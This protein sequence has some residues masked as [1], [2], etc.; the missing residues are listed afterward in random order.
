MKKSRRIISGVIAC[1]LLM[2]NAPFYM[3]GGL[4]KD[5]AKIV[6]KAADE[7]LPVT[8]DG[9]TYAITEE[10]AVI[11]G[12]TGI[13]TDITIPST[14]ESKNVVTIGEAA[15]RNN[16]IIESV[17]IPA[18][19]TK[20]EERAFVNCKNLAK[21][22]LNEGLETIG[23]TAFY[24]TAIEEIAI[25]STLTNAYSAFGCWNGDNTKLKKIVFPANYETI[26]ES[27]C[28]YCN[29]LEEIVFSEDVTT[30][31]ERAFSGCKLT[32]IEF[33]DTVET[34]GEG[35]FDGCTALKDVTLNKGLKTIGQSAFYN[36][37]IEEISIPAT[38][39]NAY[40]AFGYWNGD[41]TNLKKITFPKNYET[42]PEAICRYCNNLE[43]IVFSENI[44]TI[45]ERAFSGCKLTAIEFPD[46]VETIGESAFDGCT[47]L[48]DVTLNK[49]LKTIG[50]SAFYN[51]AIEEISIPASLTEAYSA[52]GYW[53]GDNTNLKKVIF[54]KN[55]ETIP[56]SICRYC[57]NLEE[58]VFSV[59]V[60]TIGD[61]AFEGCSSLTSLEVPDTVETIGEAAFNNCTAMSELTLNEGLKTIGQSAF[62]NT[63]IEEVKIPSTLTSGFSAFGYWNGS[64]TKLKKAVIAKRATVIPDSLFRYCYAL[65][66]VEIPETVETIGDNAFENCT[67]LA[68]IKLNEGLTTIG[69]NAFY[70]TAIT[71]ITIP[72]TVTNAAS[73]FGYWN[74]NATKLENVKFADGAKTIPEIMFDYCHSL[75]T[76]EIPDTIEEIG[77]Y[78]FRNCEV[79]TTING[80]QNII[81]FHN[82]S[83]ENCN[84]FFDNR[85]KL[86]TPES[87][88]Q[89]NTDVSYANGI[90]NYTIRYQ[91]KDHVAAD[92]KNYSL[93]LDIPDGMS[94]IPES[95]SSDAFDA[96]TVDLTKKN[97]KLDKNK[98]VV[99]F[100]CRVDKNSNYTV[101]AAIN[102]N[103]NNEGWTQYIDKLD[104]SAAK[105]TCNAPETTNTG[106]IAVYGITEKGADVEIYVDDEKITTVKAN[107]YTGKY[108][109]DIT[110][111]EKKKDTYAI[112]AQNGK[113]ITD[114]IKVKLNKTAPAVKSVNLTYNNGAKADI[115]KVFTHGEAPVLNYV[116]STPLVFEVATENNDNIA[117]VFVTSSKGNNTKSIE[118]KWDASKK[119]WVT[120]GWFDPD[121][122]GYIP[123]SLNI[124]IEEKNA[125]ETLPYYKNNGYVKFFAEP[126][127]NV[128]EA[129]EGN[130]VKDAAIT[131]YYKESDNAEAIVWN[132][133]DYDQA[134]PILTDEYGNFSVDVPEGKWKI[135]C[136]KDGYTTAESDWLDVPPVQTE[137]NFSIVSKAA[138]EIKSAEFKDGKLTVVFSKFVDVSTVDAKTISVDTKAAITVAPQLLAEGD[139]YADTFV[140]T[141]ADNAKSVIITNGIKSYAGVAAAGKS[142]ALTATKSEP[143]DVNGDGAINLKD[144]VLLRRYIAGGW[145][146]TVDE[147]I[148]DVN[149]DKTVNLKDVVLLR[150]YIAGGW[151]VALKK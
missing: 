100:S 40:S 59:N 29:N 108:S 31:G 148:A 13:K 119:T 109:A 56:D 47:A 8:E 79:L 135:E 69:E 32:A 25:P 149:S 16:E 67:A 130:K 98:G 92:V 127:G 139:K 83:F 116:Q 120:D 33:P 66:T 55:Y 61:R 6:A 121:N 5:N 101:G 70:N 48:K 75:K 41:N 141:G 45:G 102:F 85:F 74:G 132:A 54:P 115:T 39:T 143:G 22:T 10:G 52:F 18:S 105:I 103:Y 26:P 114:E 30:I 145:N 35:A 20:I 15:F 128:Y 147:D 64:D 19:V 91:F 99:K 37:A 57:N 150:R 71:D 89:Q 1:S 104:V 146:V 129:V 27:I 118:A 42:I 51:T 131:V 90:V 53:N 144:V 137:V 58:I 14:I 38:L 49:G 125:E 136:K 122:H 117:K 123:G 21:V 36:T 46:T 110:L 82:K 134:N 86:L 106:K 140:I 44:K 24:N 96:A 81:K 34:I 138:P 76:V 107:A 77:N 17:I 3:N 43:E 87:Y 151:D 95:L 113:L 11:K 97:I 93:T 124:V 80:G 78:A 60:K 68:D 72:S 7:E 112:Y 142:F 62:Y 111:P 23:E 84:N 94:I 63:A 133:A 73:A 88:F 126:T 65:D 28:R 50:Q 12:Y 4:D 2:S 9:F